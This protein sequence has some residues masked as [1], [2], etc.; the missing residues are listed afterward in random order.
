MKTHLPLKIKTKINF[1]LKTKTKINFPLKTKTK[2]NFPL[3]TKKKTH[4]LLKVKRR[5]RT[6]FPL[7]M[8]SLIFIFVFA[9]CAVSLAESAIG[10][11]K[12][13]NPDQISS[14]GQATVSLK[15]Q[16]PDSGSARTSPVD[17]ISLIDMST[18]M[19]W[20]MNVLDQSIGELPSD[21][22]KIKSFD[23][24]QDIQGFDATLEI[25]SGSNRYLR[26]KS[27]SGKWYGY[28]EANPSCVVY[29]HVQYTDRDYLRVKAG[30][31]ET[32]TWEAWGKGS[33]N[34]AMFMVGVP[35]SRSET[36]KEADKYL[37]SLLQNNDQ[38]GLVSFNNAAWV[39]QKLIL[40]DSESARNQ[41]NSRVESL[42]PG[43][44]TAIGRG[45]ASAVSN[46]SGAN[47]AREEALKTIVLVSDGK[48]TE[49]SDPLAQAQAAKNAGIKIYTVAL[50]EADEDL[51]QQIAGVTGGAYYRANSLDELKAAYDD[52]VNSFDAVIQEGR[53]VEVLPS[54]V[55]YLGNA[56]ME[57]ESVVKNADGTTQIIWNNINIGNG[58]EKILSF[59]IKVQGNPGSYDIGVSPDS[60]L[61]YVDSSG[62]AVSVPFSRA[63]V[64][65]TGGSPGV[66][67][68]LSGGGGGFLPSLSISSQQAGKITGQGA[69][70]SWHTN[71]RSFCRIAYDSSTHE[72]IGDYAFAASVEN[73]ESDSAQ[74][75][76]S[77]D[78]SDLTDDTMYYWR[79]SCHEPGA[80]PVISSSE[81]KFLTLPA[82]FL[83]ELQ[84]KLGNIIPQEQ[85]SAIVSGLK[86]L[87][88]KAGNLL[89]VF[90]PDGASSEK[91]GQQLVPGAKASD[92][93]VSAPQT[94]GEKSFW[95]KLSSAIRNIGIKGWIT[96]IVIIIVVILIAYLI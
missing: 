12:E 53:V 38:A 11:I 77:I 31:Y 91:D 59:D 42:T 39:K 6:L 80:S 68:V 29:S 8:A 4:F 94:L 46:L 48:E 82:G 25:Q 37:I 44:A 9:I 69:E 89:A 28:F 95:E 27:P 71:L 84:D 79:V 58:Q 34:S 62:E 52:I 81:E 96:I 55:E 92:S 2:I 40:L 18:S 54:Y 67:P 65:I 16:A 87:K 3:T 63:S 90:S 70:L 41:F 15:I 33:S 7:A 26:L 88:T 35:P 83:G 45:I 51:F 20:F 57:P 14:G 10:L 66:S 76:H 47:G 64:E 60:R 17:L 1:P 23:L 73:E 93:N 74:T 30:C 85:A 49:G 75:Y 5:K 43:G 22:E 13:V 24:G 72:K 32:G 36:A 78:T 21:W 86:S 56:T 61:E 19:D 50:G